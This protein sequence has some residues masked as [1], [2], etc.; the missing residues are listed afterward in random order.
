ML[1]CIEF[2]HF[3]LHVQTP[4]EYETLLEEHFEQEKFA[5]YTLVPESTY[6]YDSIWAA[7]LALNQTAEDIN[8]KAF[9]NDQHRALEDFS[10]SDDEMGSILSKAIE[11][12][13]FTG[14]SVS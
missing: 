13:N 7:A 1:L 14:V 8:T 9:K 2:S 11:S 5:G 3:I 6:G 4:G 10:Y 12:V